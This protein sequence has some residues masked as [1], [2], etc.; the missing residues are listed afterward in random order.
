MNNMTITT[1][2]FTEP[3]TLHLNKKAAN[4]TNTTANNNVR[5]GT[6]SRKRKRKQNTDSQDDDD[7]VNNQMQMRLSTQED[8]EIWATLISNLCAS[9]IT[10]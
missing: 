1:I 2:T 7:H 3:P 4:I 9:E 10:C 6:V 5:D 8:C